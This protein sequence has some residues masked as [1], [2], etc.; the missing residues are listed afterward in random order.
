MD[1]IKTFL[2]QVASQLRS[3][4]KEEREPAR[5]ILCEMA[6]LLGPAYLPHIISVLKAQLQRGYQVHILVYTTHAILSHVLLSEHGGQKQ[7]QIGSS[8]NN[9]EGCL[10]VAIEPIMDMVNDEL[11]SNLMEEKKVAAIVKKTAEAS[12]TVSYNMLE[13]LSSRMSKAMLGPMLSQLLGR[14][15]SYY[16][17]YYISYI[18]G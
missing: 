1:F 12:K 18:L 17:N 14:C 3:R 2:F 6:S 16:Y 9:D 7:G 15:Q 10:D 5:R 11:F 4:K 13:L 8:S